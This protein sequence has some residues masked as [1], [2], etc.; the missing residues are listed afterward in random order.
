MA[1][2]KIVIC[3]TNKNELEG[4][5]R[6]CKSICEKKNLPVT[7]LTFGESKTLVF[8]MGDPAFN[9][10]VDI[11]IIEPD[12]GC[13]ALASYLRKQLG[14][15]GVILYLS[16]SIDEKHFYSAFDVN[17]FSFIKKGDLNRFGT[18]FAEA[19]SIA[20]EKERLFIAVSYLGEY[21]N[22]DIR[23]IYSFETAEN[24]H[25]A[26]L[27][28]VKYVGGEFDFISTLSELEEKLKAV[29]FLRVQRSF[30][31]S[32]DAIHKVSYQE[33][34]L[35]NGESVPVSRGAG[36]EIKEAVHNWNSSGAY[37]S[38]AG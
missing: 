6:V 21:R 32:I 7:I 31:V 34:I 17:A 33:V 25:S 15:K 36:S 13:E 8:E 26:N 1:N 2:L 14:Y 35:N 16:R 11:M 5:A 38:I 24:D 23:D 18:V 9:D 19:L 28:R 30:I 10:S 29:G 27:I 22:I 37:F 4:H 12:G 3:D 20:K